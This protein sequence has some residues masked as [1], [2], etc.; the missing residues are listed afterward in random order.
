MP[1]IHTLPL[2]QGSGDYPEFLRSRLLKRDRIRLLKRGDD[3]VDI[4]DENGDDNGQGQDED[5]DGLNQDV[6]GGGDVIDKRNNMVR[7]TFLF[8][9][10][11]LVRE[12]LE[13]IG[14]I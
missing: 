10:Q 13:L 14:V 2:L 5:M 6:G 4:D 12:T 3:D 8:Y 1:L 9:I 7:Y 11:L